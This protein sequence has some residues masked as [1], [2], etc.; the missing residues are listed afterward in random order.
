MNSKRK[1][2]TGELDLVRW[3]R[4]HGFPDARRGQ[5]HKGGPDSPDIVGVPGWHI[6]CK[7]DARIDIGTKALADACE[8]ADREVRGNPCALPVVL[9]RRNREAW[10]ATLYMSDPDYRW[11]GWATID[12]ETWAEIAGGKA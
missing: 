6:E 11:S 12:A 9:W 10:R 2:K 4:A 3:L 8:Q 1:G 7:R 5:Q